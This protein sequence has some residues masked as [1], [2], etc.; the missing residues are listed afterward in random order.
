[1]YFEFDRTMYSSYVLYA[2]VPMWGGRHHVDRLAV[3]TAEWPTC[4]LVMLWGMQAVAARA[5]ATVPSRS[6]SVQF[7]NL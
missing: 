6:A 1:M 3:G 5:L 4:K 2:H 7:Q